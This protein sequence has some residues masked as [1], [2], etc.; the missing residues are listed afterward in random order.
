M[1]ELLAILAA[2]GIGVGLVHLFRWRCHWGRNE[3][4]HAVIVVGNAGPVVEWHLWMFAFS[5][6]LQARYTKITLIDEGSSDDT[7]RI[8]ERMISRLAA[9]WELI[10]VSSPAEAKRLVEQLPDVENVLVIR[11]TPV[12]E[13]SPG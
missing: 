7:L 8:A 10:S 1:V 4:S 3:T 12:G 2:Y 5:Q 9:D 11:G 6:W 13:A